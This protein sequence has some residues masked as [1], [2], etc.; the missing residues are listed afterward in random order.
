MRRSSSVR[1]VSS[2]VGGPGRRVVV[3][4]GGSGSLGSHIARLVYSRWGDEVAEI[5]LFDRIP[6]QQAL[7][8]SITGFTGRQDKPKVSYYPG[9][10]L[11]LNDLLPACVKADVVIHCAAAVENGSIINRRKMKEVNIEG[12]RNVVQACLDCGVQALVFSG[13]ISQV[14][15]SNTRVKLEIAEGDAGVRV[16]PRD[17]DLLFP[18]YGGTKNEA[19]K[20]VL[21]AN[22]RAG[23]DGILLHTCSLRCP[24][25]FGEND[26]EFILTGLKA[27]KHC[28]G[29]FIPLGFTNATMQSL[30]FGNGAYAHVLGA[31]KLLDE[32]TRSTIG[33]K[34]YY[35]GDES[36]A[37]QFVDFQ[38][39]FLKPL[40]YRVLPMFKIP[41]FL[42]IALAYF[43]EFLALILAYLRVDFR[44]NLNR[45]S[46]RYL[47][48]SHSLSWK[49][50]K[51]ELDYR[52][53]FDHET[54]VAKS[55]E[56]YRRL[57]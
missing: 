9:D 47:K 16:L 35:I 39:Q 11:K 3:I 12:T 50:A 21:D 51:R 19:E 24:P 37:C 48:L 28:C 40:G 55:V 53:L 15:T 2:D 13:S 8:T 14:L 27:A 26:R 10:V 57:L 34:F 41:L 23:K 30:Y 22:D 56:Y 38:A 4:T 45:S 54:A 42:L 25:M 5:R 17:G 7:I 18:Y 44:T 46:L 29:Y 32:T 31:Q 43:F 52:P 1:S 33:G 20:L 49:K 6:P 36:P